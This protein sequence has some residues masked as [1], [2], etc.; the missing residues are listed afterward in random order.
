MP[1]DASGN[2]TLPN[3]YQAVTGQTILASQ[4]NP[5]LEDVAAA[6]SQVLLR[7]GVAP[8]AGP[9]NMNGFRAN[10]LADGVDPQDAATVGQTNLAT[11]IGAVM[12]YA[13]ATAPV[14]WLF[15]YGQA[16]SRAT[17]AAL[18]TAISTTY[19]AGDGSTTF[20]LPDCRGR[21]VAG[22]DDMGGVSA[23]RLTAQTGGVNGDTL[24]ASGGAETHT[25]T[26]TQMPSHTH[27]VTGTA[28][29]GGLHSHSPDGQSSFIAAGSGPFSMSGGAGTGQTT[30]TTADGVHGHSVT[31][32]AAA[33]GSG[34]AHNNVQ[35]TIIFNK[36]IRSGV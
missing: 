1:Y 32:T 6:L 35:P 17:Y 11:P 18:F 19:G 34:A 5:P 10:S 2:F 9:L 15:C 7:S 3:G 28:A 33:T 14:G 12:D 23:N 36:I 16:V 22:K 27:S 31:G 4:H 24:G 29:P 8:M 13:G 25:L 26:I 21:T 20:N 30:A